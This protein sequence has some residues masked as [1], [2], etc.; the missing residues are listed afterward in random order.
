MVEDAAG[1]FSK[2]VGSIALK[3]EI[4]SLVMVSKYL[5]D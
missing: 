2:I 1:L 4:M 5:V 3:R